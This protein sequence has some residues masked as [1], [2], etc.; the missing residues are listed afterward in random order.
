METTQ[1][2]DVFKNCVN[3]NAVRGDEVFCWFHQDWKR[4]DGTKCAPSMRTE[5]ADQSW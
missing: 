3:V 2:I 5:R 1:K 4:C